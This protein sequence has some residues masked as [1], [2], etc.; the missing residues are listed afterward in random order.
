MSLSVGGHHIFLWI[1]TAGT[2]FTIS[3]AVINDQVIHCDKVNCDQ[4]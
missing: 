4:L 2:L 1:V 3:S